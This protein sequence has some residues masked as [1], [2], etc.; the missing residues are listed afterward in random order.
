VALAI[1]K[2][3]ATSVFTGL[4]ASCATHSFSPEPTESSRPAKNRASVEI[5][6]STA[7]RWRM[8]PRSSD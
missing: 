8:R 5:S 7:M 1:K 2:L 6:A 4:R 3:I